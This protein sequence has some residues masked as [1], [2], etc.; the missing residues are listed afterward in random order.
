MKLKLTLLFTLLITSSLFAQVDGEKKSTAIPAVENKDEKK[1]ETPKPAPILI[2]P[3]EKPSLTNTSKENISGIKI[4][5]PT[6]KNPNKQFSMIDNSTLINPSTIF[7]KKWADEKKKREAESLT[8]E[9]LG[10][11]FL[12]DFKITGEFINVICRDFGEEDGDLVRVIV[13]DDV[14]V[15]RLELLNGFKSFKI[16]LVDGINKVDFYAI[17]QG[18]VGYN[19]AEFQIFSDTETLIFTKSWHL[20]TNSKATLVFIKQ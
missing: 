1:E 12:G 10:D 18:L 15:A 19:T 13:N 17:N 11:Q 14:Y 6:Y 20:S 4:K 9:K 5:S 8:P 16:P 3:N 7:E 2:T